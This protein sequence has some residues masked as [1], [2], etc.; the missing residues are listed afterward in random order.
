[1]LAVFITELTLSVV[2]NAYG[3]GYIA[4]QRNSIMY[5]M[6]IQALTKP[7]S[8]LHSLVLLLIACTNF[9][10]FSARTKK[11]LKIEYVTKR[12]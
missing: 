6:R 12:A 4:R 10:E 9:G 8:Y 3:V 7:L 2:V 5:N 11:S 1:M